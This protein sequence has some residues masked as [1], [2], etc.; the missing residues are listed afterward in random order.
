MDK[1]II[2]PAKKG[3]TIYTKSG[4]PNC[5]KVKNYLKS[6]NAPITI[7]DCDD[8]LIENKEEFLKFISDLSEIT[9]KV[10]PIV[11]YEEK[12]IGGYSETEKHYNMM[13]AFSNNDFF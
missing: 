11:F 7:I 3:Y 5:V 4:C 12:Y 6:V 10:F 9:I 1:E 13:S 8:Y 2:K